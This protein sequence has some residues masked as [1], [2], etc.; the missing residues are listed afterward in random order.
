LAALR[1]VQLARIRHRFR[2]RVAEARASF[3][4]ECRK[5]WDM[6]PCEHCTRGRTVLK[7]ERE[8][9]LRRWGVGDR[10]MTA[11]L[12][13]Y[14]GPREI[15]D[16]LR[17]FISEWDVRRNLLLLGPYGSGKSGLASACLSALYP[18]F[19]RTHRSVRFVSTVTLLAMLRQ[20][21]DDKRVEQ[22]H[23]AHIMPT[24]LVLDD[25]GAERLTEWGHERV[26]QIVNDRYERH[27]PTWVTSNL[28]VD[29][30]A[31]AVGERTFSRLLEHSEVL[32]IN[33]P[34]LRLQEGR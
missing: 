10:F 30:L 25:L 34:N 32:V 4:G 24:L 8:G 6:G 20:A 17:V 21:Q 9:T 22:T 14:P 12:D 19:S 18:S 28:T 5:C 27:K 26:Y 1:Q 2:D 23:R 16:R 11:T 3:S 15:T 13:S 7:G 33:G 29:A 31:E